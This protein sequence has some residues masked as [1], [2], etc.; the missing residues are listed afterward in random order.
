MAA[1]DKDRGHPQLG[2][3]I[4]GRPGSQCRPPAQGPPQPSLESDPQPEEGTFSPAGRG[5]GQVLTP[6]ERWEDWPR[7]DPAHQASE[8]VPLGIDT[9]TWKTDP[10]PAEWESGVP[11][12]RLMGKTARIRPPP[13]PAPGAVKRREQE[14]RS[15]ARAGARSR[16]AAF[17]P[18]RQLL[19]PY[20]E[21]GRV[22]FFPG[23]EKARFGFHVSPTLAPQA[24][25]CGSPAR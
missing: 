3:S 14:P 15:P 7:A 4:Q 13:P 19:P 17:P 6:S 22:S 2:Q 8:W 11:E 24:V 10:P 21:A 12:L 9:P 25:R 1:T 23:Q 5:P 20:E 18:A 16:P